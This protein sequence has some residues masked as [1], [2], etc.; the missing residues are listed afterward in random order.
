VTGF[1]AAVVEAWQELRIHKL[2]VLLSLIGVG[3]AVCSL[4]MAVAVANV[5]QQAMVEQ[6]EKQDGR[7]AYFGI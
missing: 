4:T 6:Y 2:R 3:V 7:P 5:A 1:A